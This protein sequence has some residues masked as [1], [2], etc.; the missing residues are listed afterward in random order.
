MVDIDS[1]SEVE[2]A[3]SHSDESTGALVVIAFLTLV[4]GCLL[5]TCGLL[6]GECHDV[7]LRVEIDARMKVM[8]AQERAAR[9]L[10]E[11]KILRD[12]NELLRAALEV[13]KTHRSPNH[14][15]HGT[16]LRP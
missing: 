2:S 8:E 10:Q 11:A 15:A 16:A 9:A 5:V 7:R 1:N 3:D 14:P 4:I 13:V 6:W 12:Q